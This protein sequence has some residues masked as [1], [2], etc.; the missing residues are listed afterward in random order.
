MTEIRLKSFHINQFL[1]QKQ[2][3]NDIRLKIMSFLDYLAEY[4]RKYK[5]EE[6]E[7][8]GMLNDTLK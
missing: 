1:I 4:K 6:N 2:I 5:L 8:L 7:V 3:P